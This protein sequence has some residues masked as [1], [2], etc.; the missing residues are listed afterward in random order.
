MYLQM[1]CIIGGQSRIPPVLRVP[2]I[3]VGITRKE[4]RE[5]ARNMYS[6]QTPFGRWRGFRLTLLSVRS[7]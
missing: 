6:V 7:S 2:A 1:Y 5:G 3:V 4:G